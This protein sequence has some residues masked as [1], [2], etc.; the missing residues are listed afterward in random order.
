M[1]SDCTSLEKPEYKILNVESAQVIDAIRNDFLIGGDFEWYE[2]KP[3]FTYEIQCS[4]KIIIA[5]PIYEGNEDD[6]YYVTGWTLT[7]K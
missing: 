4:D 6:G 3:T 2:T 7:D 1:F 5:T